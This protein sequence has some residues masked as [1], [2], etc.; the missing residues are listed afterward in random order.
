[1]AE[2]FDPNIPPKADTDPCIE[3]D[4]TGPVVVLEKPALGQGNLVIDRTKPF[5]IKVGW[6]MF[7]NLVPLWLTAMSRHQHHSEL[8]RLGSV[9]GP[10]I[11]VEEP[12]T[13]ALPA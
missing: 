7:G 5:D 6:R 11:K 1:M 2:H 3:G 4:F 8:R 12:Q 9:E 10:I 13:A